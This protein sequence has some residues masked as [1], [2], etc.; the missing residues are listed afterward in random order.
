MDANQKNKTFNTEDTEK[1]GGETFAGGE[2]STSHVIGKPVGRELTRMDANQ[3]N[4][5]LP[6]CP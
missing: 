5:T 3:K 1:H 6:G 4:K 2:L